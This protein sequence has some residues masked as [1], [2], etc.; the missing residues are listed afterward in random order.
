MP[1]NPITDTVVKQID[2][3]TEDPGLEIAKAVMEIESKDVDEVS[4]IYDAMDG[5]LD[6]IFE[7]P[8]PPNSSV[9]ISFT[10]EGYRVTLH[11]DGTATFVRNHHET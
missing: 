1:I 4:P 2:T 6:D 11:Q 10:Y 3:N 5:L 9:V 7:N 8:P